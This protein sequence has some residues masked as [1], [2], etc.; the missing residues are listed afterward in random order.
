MLIKSQS[1]EG[2]QAQNKRVKKVNNRSEIPSGAIDQARQEKYQKMMH[3]VSQKGDNDHYDIQAKNVP[4]GHHQR[5]KSTHEVTEMVILEKPSARQTVHHSKERQKLENQG[6]KYTPQGTNKAG[7]QFGIPADSQQS[8][9]KNL[10]ITF[11]ADENLMKQ[12]KLKQQKQ[13][14]SKKK[15]V[16]QVQKNAQI[17]QLNSNHANFL[18]TASGSNTGG[19]PSPILSSKRV[20]QKILAQGGDGSM[21]PP[22]YNSHI[23]ENNFILEK[24]NSVEESKGPYNPFHNIIEQQIISDFEESQSLSPLEKSNQQLIHNLNKKMNANMYIE[25]D[26]FGKEEWNSVRRD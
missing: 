3:K 7:V 9:Q 5:I 6:A 17:M 20:P 26:S 19:Q 4:H 2:I 24:D 10:K 14:Q 12:H 16:I 1:P 25:S 13:I 22:T 18:N 21:S 23:H 11:V 8:S 15:E